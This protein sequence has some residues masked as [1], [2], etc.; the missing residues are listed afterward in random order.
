MLRVLPDDSKQTKKPVFRWFRQIRRAYESLRC[1][2]FEI[3]RRRQQQSYKPIALPFAHTHGV[4]IMQARWWQVPL[5]TTQEL[6]NDST[7]DLGRVYARE[8]NKGKKCFFCPMYRFS[9]VIV[10]ACIEV[11]MCTVHTVYVLYRA[12]VI[13]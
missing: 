12:L 10:V 7:K 11:W 1:L 13:Q 2:D 8:N 5:V 9:S 6:V 3:R 4:T